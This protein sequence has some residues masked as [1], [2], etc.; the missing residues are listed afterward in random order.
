MIAKAGVDAI[1]MG[2]TGSQSAKFTRIAR[3]KDKPCPGDATTSFSPPP[4][5]RSPHFAPY[6]LERQAPRSSQSKSDQIRE[7][8]IVP[9]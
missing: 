1:R 2:F 4:P 5:R 3:L 9:T 8:Q 7:N 6:L